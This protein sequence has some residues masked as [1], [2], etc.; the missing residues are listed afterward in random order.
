MNFKNGTIVEI[1]SPSDIDNQIF[2]FDN[3]KLLQK[4]LF[5]FNIEDFVGE[6]GFITEMHENG[7]RINFFNQDISY[8]SEDYYF[9]YGCLEKSQ[10]VKY[11]NPT[12]KYQYLSDSSQKYCITIGSVKIRADN[13]TFEIGYSVT[14]K[15]PNDKFNKA[16]ARHYASNSYTFYINISESSTH[17]ECLLRILCDIYLNRNV[18]GYSDRYEQ[19][20][21][22]KIHELTS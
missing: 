20:I 10:S 16:I 15:N 14:F 13:N 8:I 21:L 18:Y 19:I 1:K 6:I 22:E 2:K 9:P 5:N 17:K 3:E 11:L 4:N 12:V 7:A